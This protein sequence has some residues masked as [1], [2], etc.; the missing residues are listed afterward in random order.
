MY[1]YIVRKQLRRYPNR[2]GAR[3]GPHIGLEIDAQY[4]VQ[5]WVTALGMAGLNA[6]NKSPVFRTR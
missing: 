6:S 4:R 3:S 2:C 1:S 5:A